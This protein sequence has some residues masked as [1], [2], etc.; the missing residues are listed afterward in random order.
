MRDRRRG[1]RWVPTWK[2]MVP[3][4]LSSHPRGFGAH[5]KPDAAEITKFAR[6]TGFPA[7]NLEKILRGGRFAVLPRKFRT[8]D[9]GCR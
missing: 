5:M 3:E 1:N 7:A 4:T 8:P 2:L 6:D 9:M